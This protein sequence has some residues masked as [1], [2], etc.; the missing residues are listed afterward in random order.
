MTIITNYEQM[1]A[2]ANNDK[3]N[4]IP[5]DVYENVISV[6]PTEDNYFLIIIKGYDSVGKES[7]DYLVINPIHIISITG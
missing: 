2:K 6:T 1:E 5:Y 7:T 3:Y 4:N